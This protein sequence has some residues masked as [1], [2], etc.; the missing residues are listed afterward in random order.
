MLTLEDLL[1][2]SGRYPDRA[3]SP[4]RN[5]QVDYNLEVLLNRVNGLLIRLGRNPKVSSGFRPSASNA[6]AGGAP[7][8]GH[9]FG[10]AVDLVD[11][12][13]TLDELIT[14]E[15]LTEFDLW[16]EDP[17]KTVGWCHLDITPRKNRTF[18]V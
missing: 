18:Y 3:N 15:L 8:S 7:K 13:G 14:D 1:T 11:T 10:K 4:E 9:L 12:D 2:S 5:A 6:L 16:R 17:A